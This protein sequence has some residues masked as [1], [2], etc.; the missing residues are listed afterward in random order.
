MAEDSANA[1]TT[2]ELYAHVLGPGRMEDRA[3]I[4][5]VPQF[6]SDDVEVLQMRSIIGTGRRFLGHRGVIQSASEIIRDFAD[7][8]FSPEEI[9]AVGDR[10]GSAVLFRGK[11]RRSEAPVEIRVGHLFTLRDGLIFRWEVLE[12]PDAALKAVGL[13]G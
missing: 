8:M 12:D 3:T 6:F 7:P 5:V 10:V 1:A 2:R 13:E 4:D 11:G 9:H